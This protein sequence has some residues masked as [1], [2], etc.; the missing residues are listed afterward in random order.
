M[1]TEPRFST[2]WCSL[3]YQKEILIFFWPIQGF[4]DGSESEAQLCV[5]HRGEKVIDVY[6][7]SEPN[8]EDEAEYDEDTLQIVYSS[9]KAGFP[10]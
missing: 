7:I 4:R 3:Y 8:P 9:S 1:S 10:Y 6:G 2:R 5:Y